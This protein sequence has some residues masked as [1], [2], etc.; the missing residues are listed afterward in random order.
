MAKTT[1]ILGARG[2]FV[3]PSHLREKYGLDTGSLFILEDRPDGILLRP[4]E[5]TPVAKPVKKKTSRK[6][7]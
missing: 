4:A 5:A 2:Q 1:A 3:I 6:K 7:G